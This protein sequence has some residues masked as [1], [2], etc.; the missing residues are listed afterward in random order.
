[1]IFSG[2][3]IELDQTDG[4]FLPGFNTHI[5]YDRMF[6]L[7]INLEQGYHEAIAQEFADFEA[8]RQGGATNGRS[9]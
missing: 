9:I 4:W 6:E 3:H 7:Y 1:M 5:G 2:T 8:A